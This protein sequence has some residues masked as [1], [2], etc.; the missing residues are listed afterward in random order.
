MVSEGVDV[1]QLEYN[2]G[3]V[4]ETWG[5]VQ[6]LN[7]NFKNNC[8]EWVLTD[9]ALCL[10]VPPNNLFFF[11]A[12]FTVWSKANICK[13]FKPLDIRIHHRS[14]V[15][16]I[17]SSLSQ[18]FSDGTPTV[19][20]GGG[21]GTGSF[22]HSTATGRGGGGAPSSTRRPPIEDYFSIDDILACHQRVPCQFELPVY[23]LGFLNPNS[24][25]EHLQ[26]GT[27]MEVPLWLARMLCSRRRQIVN[28]GLPKAYREAQR[29]ILSADANVVDLYKLGPYYYSMGVKLLRFEHFER[30]DLSKSLLE[31]FLNRF[32]WIMDSSQ[33]AFQSDTTSL[34]SRLD[35][36]ERELF[37]TGQR[38][39]QDMEKWERG[40]SHKIMSSSVVQNRRKRK[41]EPSE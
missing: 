15:T 7:S 23:R 9:L 25:D 29:D 27:K 12:V 26:V 31:T 4:W 17:M 39:V 35:E 41:R 11:R 3:G 30:A 10:L 5:E 6:E 22:S 16:Q 13:Q 32:R 18:S 38:A 36:K 1:L 20:R 21:H 14:Y 33:N 8:I 28:V 37:R 40:E 34:M 24:N 19:T 2:V